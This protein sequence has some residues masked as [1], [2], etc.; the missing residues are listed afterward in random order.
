MIPLPVSSTNY[1]SII[2]DGLALGAI[3]LLITAVWLL[4]PDHRTDDEDHQGHSA[5]FLG[6]VLASC[7]VFS[8]LIMYLKSI[9]N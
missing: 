4:S 3:V 8:T 7:W 1:W 6:L 2:N 9:W 5:A